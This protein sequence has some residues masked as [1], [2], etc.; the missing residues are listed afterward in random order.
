MPKLK[1]N[2]RAVAIAVLKKSNTALTPTEIVDR[3]KKKGLLKSTG[4]TPEAT[5]RGMFSLDD[6]KSGKKSA[7]KRVQTGKYS[8]NK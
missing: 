4:K 3:A 8:L 1:Q 5:I 6:T 7:F 2:Y